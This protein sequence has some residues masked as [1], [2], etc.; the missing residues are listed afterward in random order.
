MRRRSATAFPGA[1]KLA[2]LPQLEVVV[3]LGTARPGML[4]WSDVLARAGEVSSDALA[5][6]QAALGFDD[7]IN[8]QYTSGTTGF[9]K[10]AT[11][12]H[13]NILNNGYFV[14]RLMNFS[15]QDRL[16][17]PVPLYHCFGMVMGNLGCVSHGATMIY[18][19]QAFDAEAVLRAVAGRTRYRA[20]RR[21]DDVH[22]GT[23]AAEFRAISI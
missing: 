15:D 22:R 7:P 10:G 8:I 3:T 12:S 16:V 11:L 5:Q 19:E 2:R 17:I 18:P 4:T 14:A 23:R 9:P 13:H 20:L 1:L 6:R 21:A